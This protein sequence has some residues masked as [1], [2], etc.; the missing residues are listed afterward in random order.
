[1]RPLPCKWCSRSWSRTSGIGGGASLLHWDGRRVQVYDGRETAPAA[2]D[3][4]L[5]LKPDGTPM[6]FY[7][8]VAWA[9]ARWGCS[10]ARC[11][12][13]SQPTASTVA[14]LWAKLFEPAI[15]LAEGGFKVS[16]RLYGLLR[17]EQ[18]P[19]KDE[20]AARYFYKLDGDPRDVGMVVRNPRA[21]RGL[22]PDRHAGRRRVLSRA[23]SRAT[24]SPK[25]ATTPPTRAR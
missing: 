25:S 9:A 6:A 14:R 19:R 20:A 1:M 3:E 2:A 4:K 18:H 21:G 13:W 24:S 11:A 15:Q 17:N 7:D 16:S 23:P 8:A 12:C 10:S 5:F 22:P